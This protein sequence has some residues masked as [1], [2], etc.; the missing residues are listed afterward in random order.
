M[1]TPPTDLLHACDRRLHRAL[2][3]RIEGRQPAVLYDAVRDRLRES[4][5]TE[6][7]TLLLAT[8]SALG[9]DPARAALADGDDATSREA[10][11]P[12]TI[13]GS[14][15]ALDA[16]VAIT[17]VETGA[18][19]H[20]R[21]LEG[22]TPFSLPAD[23]DDPDRNVDDAGRNDDVGRNRGT[24]IDPGTETL[25]AGDV[26]YAAAFT[27]IADDEGNAAGPTGP[28]EAVDRYALLAGTMTTVSEGL[29]IAADADGGT[30]ETTEEA[31]HRTLGSLYEAAMGLGGAVVE[32][33]EGADALRECGRHLGTAVGMAQLDPAAGAPTTDSS[34]STD[35]ASPTTDA[36]SPTTD[37][38]SPIANADPAA[39]RDR[40]RHHERAAIEAAT[41]AF[42]SESGAY[43]R[44]DTGSTATADGMAADGDR[45]PSGTSREVETLAS[46][47]RAVLDRSA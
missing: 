15:R 39:V 6:S 13:P 33:D 28:I 19:I 29:T 27:Q 41:D 3:T 37:A 38:A 14:D 42:P 18:R 5:V 31:V 4:A 16:A 10:A 44:S 11:T 43:S 20:A 47:V 7:G 1:A 2:A 25:L 45:A 22:P 21:L 32:R 26:C 34:A 8:A 24:S 23:D 12:G 9:D 40:T 36:A 17:L 30:L 46:L 35:A